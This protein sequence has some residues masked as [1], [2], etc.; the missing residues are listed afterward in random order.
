V[1]ILFTRQARIFQDYQ[2][3]LYGSET[4]SLTAMEQKKIN[5]LD[6][7]CLRKICGIKWSDF[8]TNEEVQRRTNQLP[9]TSIMRRRRRLGLFVH[10]ARSDPVNDS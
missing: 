7:W 8:V 9:L 1:A 2:I 10:V 4:W 6:Q 3:F 5:V